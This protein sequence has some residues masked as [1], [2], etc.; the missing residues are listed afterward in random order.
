M[1]RIEK[2]LTC[3]FRPITL[4]GA[5][6]SYDKGV[7]FQECSDTSDLDGKRDFPGERGVPL[8]LGKPLQ[9]RKSEIR[10]YTKHGARKAVC[11]S[12]VTV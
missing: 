11:I 7:M 10:R 2:S 4:I 5:I 12:T 1:K 8:N 3:K 6:T 9:E